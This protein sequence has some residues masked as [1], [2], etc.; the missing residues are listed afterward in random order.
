MNIDVPAGVGAPSLDTTT[1]E[2]AVCKCGTKVD[3]DQAVFVVFLNTNQI[4]ILLYI[5]EYNLSVD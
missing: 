2:S 3:C 4:F 5:N 1:S